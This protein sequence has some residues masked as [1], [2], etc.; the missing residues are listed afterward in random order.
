MSKVDYKDLQRRYGDVYRTNSYG[1]ERIVIADYDAVVSAYLDNETFASIGAFPKQLMTFFSEDTMINLEGTELKNVR[2]RIAPAF[3]AQRI[4]AFVDVIRNSTHVMFDDIKSALEQSQQPVILEPL[5]RQHFL[6][7]ILS[8]STS[9]PIEEAAKP[10]SPLFNVENDL[11]TMFLAFFSP[12][13][14]PIWDQSMSALKR[15][16]D[17]VQLYYVDRLVQYEDSIQMMRTGSVAQ[18]SAVARSRDVDLLAVLAALSGLPTGDAALKLLEENPEAFVDP[19]KVALSIWF[20]GFTTTASSGHVALSWFYDIDESDMAALKEEQAKIAEVTVDDLMRG[21]PILDSFLNEVFRMAPAGAAH[22]R[23]TTR[24]VEVLGHFI[25]KDTAILLDVM[26][27]QRSP[28]YFED[29]DTFKLDRF[30]SKD[31]GP[32][33]SPMLLNFGATGGPHFC[34]GSMLAK[35]ELKV[36]FSMLLREYELDIVE[37]KEKGYRFVPD[38]G[39]REPVRVKAVR[40]VPKD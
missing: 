23:K 13:F 39:P 4:S 16:T 19:C 12:A 40:K 32:A 15:L 5:L 29:P 25:P 2:K 8:V 26:S 24:D 21:M 37:S 11:K 31:V 30:L 17:V 22:F 9:V 1:G 33:P 34:L 20:A 10:S 27:A 6:R 7:V 35:L 36:F 14:G 3:S 18:Q 38:V 28:K